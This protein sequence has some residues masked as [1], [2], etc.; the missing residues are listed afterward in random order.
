MFLAQSSQTAG[1]VLCPPAMCPEPGLPLPDQTQ[2]YQRAEAEQEKGLLCCSLGSKG[3]CL[4]SLRATVPHGSQK[5]NIVTPPLP[6]PYSCC[7]LPPPHPNLFSF[8]PHLPP[9]A[10]SQC[11]WSL[12]SNDEDGCLID[13]LSSVQPPLQPPFPLSSLPPP[14]SFHALLAEN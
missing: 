7:L 13:S 12:G 11:K 4:S 2:A 8:S 10:S 14:P 3:C 9:G 1:A 6:P 5:R